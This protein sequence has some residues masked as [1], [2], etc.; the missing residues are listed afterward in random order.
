[1]WNSDMSRTTV[2]AIIELTRAII[3]SQRRGNEREVQLRIKEIELEIERLKTRKWEARA[4]AAEAETEAM[5]WRSKAGGGRDADTTRA[6]NEAAAVAEQRAREAH[7]RVEEL[8]T[9]IV[10]A[11]EARDAG[12][13]GDT[14]ALEAWT[15]RAI[16]LTDSADG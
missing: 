4:Q 13:A 3:E 14:N 11:T 5:R 16:R 10:A 15:S 7:K 9:S 2:E 8:E 12:A 6:A 1:M